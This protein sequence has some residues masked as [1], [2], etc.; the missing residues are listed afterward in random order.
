MQS[1]AHGVI[2][3]RAAEPRVRVGASPAADRASTGAAVPRRLSRLRD[4][5]GRHRGVSAPGRRRASPDD[6]HARTAAER[7]P[8]TRRAAGRRHRRRDE[9]A[10]RR[11]RGNGQIHA[12]RAVRRRGGRAGRARGRVPVRREPGDAAHALRSSCTSSLSAAVED[13]SVTLQQVDPAELSP[14][15]F[16]HTIRAAVEQRG[17]RSIVIDSLNGYLNAMPGERFL[18]I[19]LHEL[20]MYLGQR[21]VATILIGAHQGLIGSA[22]DTPRRRQL[23]GGHGHAP[24][25]FRGAEARCGRR[26]R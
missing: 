10:D 6:D 19:Q 5:H 2:S 4:P 23:S 15:E 16:I 25:L 12:G 3:A 24:A 8:G 17:A 9:H 14:G 7:D 20:L 11:R 22:D 21:G 13:G 1:I 26:F 18:T